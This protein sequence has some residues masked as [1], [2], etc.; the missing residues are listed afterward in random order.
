MIVQIFRSQSTALVCLLIL[1]LHI[2][3]YECAYEFYQTN[4]TY[5]GL[6]RQIGDES[7]YVVSF[8]PSITDILLSQCIS[9]G[10]GYAAY[11]VASTAQGA[12]PSNYYSCVL[13]YDEQTSSDPAIGLSAYSSISNVW[14]HID[15]EDGFASAYTTPVDLTISPSGNSPNPNPAGSCGQEKICGKPECAKPDTPFIISGSH[16]NRASLS[17]LATVTY[18]NG[19]IWLVSIESNNTAQATCSSRTAET[20]ALQT[21]QQALYLRNIL[22]L[23][24]TGIVPAMS[25]FDQADLYYVM[26][27]LRGS[28]AFLTA[29]TIG[30]DQNG[31]PTTNPAA[32]VW[33]KDVTQWTLTSLQVDGSS[34]MIYCM[35]Y[36]STGHFLMSL[37][38]LTGKSIGFHY[39]VESAETRVAYGVS[40]MAPYKF[41]FLDLSGSQGIQT[42]LLTYSYFTRQSSNA[43]VNISGSLKSL[44][45]TPEERGPVSSFQRD[46]AAIMPGKT[47][48]SLEAR[49]TTIPAVA[50]IFPSFAH[51]VGGTVV[52]VRGGPFVDS[53]G[54][55]CMWVVDPD[56]CYWQAA[57]QSYNDACTWVSASVNNLAIYVTSEIMLCV[58]PSVSRQMIAQLLVSLNG[59]V[60]SQQNEA[61]EF[62]FFTTGNNLGQHYE[63]GSAKGLSLL[64]VSGLNLQ[65]LPWN[66]SVLP[67]SRCEYGDYR[68]PTT[69]NYDSRMVFNPDTCQNISVQNRLEE[70]CSFTCQTPTIPHIYC[71]TG[72]KCPLD[73]VNN[74]ATCNHLCTN[75]VSACPPFTSPLADRVGTFSDY[76]TKNNISSLN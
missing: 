8:D 50:G 40:A 22:Q 63:S 27:I 1:L 31:K 11:Q 69:Y 18:A 39:F 58:S 49:F 43:T 10:K 57:G 6:I 29:T 21:Q 66:Q 3:Y 28:S 71:L 56:A 48:V 38:V 45:W 32:V 14:F 17:I 36:N 42:Q 16:Y 9:S 19:N 46:A 41:G 53:S 24:A 12:S 68:D 64:I 72:A 25:G 60:W 52:T 23:D 7:S 37:D 44:S 74:T 59:V 76:S 13:Q 54:L 26:V 2:D 51:V 67:Q 47:F 20:S 33:Q 4:P 61:P 75:F 65:F 62:T 70:L 55:S 35:V 5:T 34:Q 15:G 73:G 30:M